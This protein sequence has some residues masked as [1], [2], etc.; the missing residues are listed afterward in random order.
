M[1]EVKEPVEREPE[2]R[3]WTVMFCFASDNPLAPG[4]ISQLKAIKNAGFHHKVNVIAQ[5]D[6]HTVNMPVHIFNVNMVERL[7]LERRLSPEKASNIGFDGKDPFVRNLV[8]DK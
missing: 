1:P 3:E 2:L 5:F 4:T 8:L 7:K 6:P